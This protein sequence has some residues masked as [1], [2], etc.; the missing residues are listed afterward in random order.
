MQVGLV[1]KQTTFDPT[2]SRTAA[3]AARTEGK[4]RANPKTSLPSPGADVAAVFPVLVQMWQRCR[5]R[6]SGGAAPGSTEGSRWP[7]E[8]A[9]LR[10]Q[11]SAAP[12]PP[13]VASC[14][15]HVACCTLRVAR[16][17]LHVARC[18][19]RVARYIL[20]PHRLCVHTKLS[21]HT[22]QSRLRAER[23]AFVRC[24][25]IAR[26]RARV[27]APRMPLLPLWRGVRGCRW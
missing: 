17:V 2:P 25:Y 5:A 19:L 3:A 26:M 13:P 14:L 8:R 22:S 15:L 11:H 6:T 4:R 12:S 27:L 21:H 16:C 18:T 20:R 9:A 23:S 24:T 7:R 10:S 1:S